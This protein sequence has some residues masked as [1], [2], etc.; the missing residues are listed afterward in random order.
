MS[1]PCIHPS[2]TLPFQAYSDL[3]ESIALQE[4]GLAH[5]INAEGEKIQ[6][7]L[8]ITEGMRFPPM[9]R[10]IGDLIAINQS[11]S[12][13]LK[14]VIKLEMVLEFKLDEVAK[15]PRYGYPAAAEPPRACEEQ[16]E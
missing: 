11:V 2:G 6:T 12:D 16:A 15:L 5:I 8:G 7:A 13:T 14:N 3:L 4:A 9:A 1:M 10:C